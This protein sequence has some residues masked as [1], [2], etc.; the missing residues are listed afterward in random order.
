VLLPDGGVVRYAA[1]LRDWS[2]RPS[3]GWTGPPK[4]LVAGGR[5]AHPTR[6]PSDISPPLRIRARGDCSSRR[7]RA[8]LG[9]RHRRLPVPS[10]SSWR[11][12]AC[13]ALASR[14]WGLRPQRGRRPAVWGSARPGCGPSGPRS[15]LTLGDGLSARPDPWANPKTVRLSFGNLQ[16]NAIA[17]AEALRIVPATGPSRRSPLDFSFG[18]S[19]LNSHLAAG[20][21]TGLT[22]AA[23]AS[24]EFCGARTRCG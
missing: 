22:A 20:A 15:T 14:G 13:L 6:R 16:A 17:I 7:R 3:G 18:L 24:A 11:P 12:A 19:I 8:A 23:P 4:A 2:A 5:A 21:A 9:R 10:C 1:T